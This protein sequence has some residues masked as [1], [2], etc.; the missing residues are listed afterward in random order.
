M[1][2]RKRR[3]SPAS[4][5]TQLKHFQGSMWQDSYNLWY[6]L[7][8][9]TLYLTFRTFCDLEFTG[10]SFNSIFLSIWNSIW[11]IHHSYWIGA[12]ITLRTMQ[13]E[14]MILHWMSPLRGIIFH[15]NKRKCKRLMDNSVNI[16][17]VQYWY[18]IYVRLVIWITSTQ[19]DSS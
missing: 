9:S 2:G 19:S 6:I 1:A 17:T 16:I 5:W 10:F 11:H 8:F 4:A 14:C 7:Y 18:Q 3:L 12:C 15:T 13:C